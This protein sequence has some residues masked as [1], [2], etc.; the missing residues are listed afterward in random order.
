[1]TGHRPRTSSAHSLR[2]LAADPIGRSLLAL[3]SDE[4]VSHIAENFAREDP[5]GEVAFL[6]AA[7]ARLGLCGDGN[8]AAVLGH[9]LW[10]AHRES[11]WRSNRLDTGSR[12][13]S[14]ALQGADWVRQT[15]GYPTVLIVPMMLAL[16]D[17]SWILTQAIHEL[18][19]SRRVTLYG[20]EVEAGSVGFSEVDKRMAGSGRAALR[21]IMDALAAGG[22]YCT[23]PDF[24]FE[25]HEAMKV[26]FFG[27]PHPISSAFVSIASRPGTMLLPTVA[28]R[29]EGDNLVCRFFEPI[30]VEDGGRYE[31]V[32]ERTWRRA[33]VAQLVASLLEM[34]I[35]EAPQQWRLLATMS[36]E[37]PQME[38]A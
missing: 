34:L 14:F 27:A 23:Y 4:I 9:Q 36:H 37:A 24:V 1:M 17:V 32:E 33:N 28:H 5:Y 25:G 7:M 19:P 3:A 20:E 21:N 6:K 11:A 12:A 31:S 13:P 35:A 29:G 10:C 30:L 2:M 38:T 26:R 15:V 18:A 16:Q 22:V 8:L